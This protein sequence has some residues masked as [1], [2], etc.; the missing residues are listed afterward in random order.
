M[1]CVK[2]LTMMTRGI[3]DSLVA[4]YTRCYLC[5]IGQSIVGAGPQLFRQNLLDFLALYHQVMANNFLLLVLLLAIQR[6]FFYFYTIF[7]HAFLN[8]HFLFSL[9]CLVLHNYMNS[10]IYK[11]YPPMQTINK[12]ST[13]SFL[14]SP[15]ERCNLEYNKLYK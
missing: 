6:D 14:R 13:L 1:E 5:R 8:A 7:L 9:I 11:L 2:R 12:I 3:G 10:S 15:C 4:V